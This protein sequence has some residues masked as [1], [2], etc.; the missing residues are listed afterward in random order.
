MD[1]EKMK[2]VI[3]P[4]AGRPEVLQLA[5]VDKPVPADNE[6]LVKVHATTV[7]VADVRVRSFNIPASFWL[8]ARII[9]G[10]TK[11][12]QPVLGAELAGE[13]EAIGKNVRLFRPG[14]QIFAATLTTFGA[15]AEYTCIAY[16]GAI[17][18]KPAH[19]SCEQAAAIP[20]GARTALHYLRKA[21]LKK[22]QK[23]LI[24][25]ASGSVGSYAVQ[26]AKHFGAEVSGICSRSNLSLVQ[27]LGADHVFDYT[28]PGFAK[29]LE[30]YDL[31]LIAVD[32]WPFSGARRFL[33]KDGV[34][35]NVTAPVKSLSMLWQ[36]VTGK[37]KILTGETIP[38][39]AEDLVFLAD[40]AR[41]GILKPLI[42]RTYSLDQIV[43]AHRY[44]E[45]GHKKGNVVVKVS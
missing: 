4:R 14:D 23:V 18:F 22:G 41:N 8:P 33:K 43:E 45:K 35:A 39:S 40:L 19:I 31:I 20:I 42:D 13:V 44:V 11:P 27:S 32:R 10:I 38:E 5:A 36:S 28:Q 17:T 12:K 24:Y 29:N 9:L 16:D 26:L 34:Y 7:T 3:C 6:V 30:Q 2:A 1:C 21:Q 37:M 15:Y 25:G